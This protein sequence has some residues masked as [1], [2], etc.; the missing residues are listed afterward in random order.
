M[1]SQAPLLQHRPYASASVIS[2]DAD[3]A[4]QEGRPVGL[5]RVSTYKRDGSDGLGDAD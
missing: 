1:C 5:N 4:V 2:R 3:V